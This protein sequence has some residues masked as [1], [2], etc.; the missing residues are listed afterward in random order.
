MGNFYYNLYGG[1]NTGLT[2]IKMG[3]DT[4]KMYWADAFNVEPYK[5]QGVTRQK[6]N[7]VLLDLS[8]KIDFKNSAS[9]ALSRDAAGEATRGVKPIGGSEYP[10]GGKNFV[11][12]L[13][14]G[15]I[16]HFDA[17]SGVLKQVYDFG[18]EISKFVFE[19]FLDGLVILPVKYDGEAI[20]GIYY[21]ILS[22]P[23]TRALNL[24]NP[25]GET[26]SATAVCMYS[27]R[28]W[29]ASGNTLYYSALGTFDDWTS[30]HD[31]GYISN[32]HSSTAEILALK[33]YG[34]SLAIYKKY[35]VFLLTG[36]DPETFAITKFAD[37][38]ANG[39]ASVLTC[40]NKQFFFNECGLF[41]L[42]LA[43]ELSQIVM[44]NN[45]AQNILKM[46]E[47]LDTQRIDDTI[48]L[49]RE[50]KNQ[51]WIFPPIKGET[52][53]KEVWIYDFE[54]DSWF[55]RIIPYEIT[56]ATVVSGEIYT[57][58][59]D[60]GGKIFVENK[61]N[62][63]SSKPIKFSFSTPFFHFSKPTTPKIV[64][65]F[66]I[67]CDSVSENNFDFS[68]SLDYQTE[69]A[70]EPETV[71]L[72]LPNVLVWEG[73]NAV[74]DPESGVLPENEPPGSA[75]VWSDGVDGCI[76][77]EVLQESLKL[78]IFDANKSVQLH[79]QGNKAGQNFTIIGFEFKDI[80]YED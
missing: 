44:S 77:S 36:S 64:E 13:S 25:L 1:L 14:D 73:K 37:K 76:W 51:I 48:V 35:E 33:E 61:G 63:F 34:G 71:T 15:R 22:T 41:H 18:R 75:T 69:S 29:V 43:G 53:Q 67:V 30:S 28:L 16:F 26:I 74:I 3:A 7:Q 72:D 65:E 78:D 55:T 80:I 17:A 45:R 50:L 27:G 9:E 6:G 23:K 10:K 38:G 60:D 5:N 39:A 32:F 40:S 11:L 46:F 12:G 58:S 47:S 24:K 21:N 68:L 20:D 62:T 4:N 31:A 79:F 57:F 59:P 66:E 70:T 52:A 8:K 2:P 49:V 56:Y 19:Y 54:L 42:S